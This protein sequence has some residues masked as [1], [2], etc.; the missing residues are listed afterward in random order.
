MTGKLK[1]LILMVLLIIFIVIQF[2][3]STVFGIG[4]TVLVQVQFD[5]GEDIQETESLPDEHISVTFHGTV[6]AELVAGKR[7]QKIVV[8]LYATSDQ[9]WSCV[10]N[11]S[12]M[13]L[14]SGD[15][16]PFTVVVTVPAG[17]KVNTVDTITVGGKGVAFPGIFQDII[18]PIQGTIVIVERY[19]RFALSTD[20]QFRDACTESNVNYNLTITNLGNCN[21]IFSLEVSN[22]NDLL[23]SQLSVSLSTFTI[24]VPEKSSNIV[25][26]T[27][28]V[29]NS[30]KCLGSHDI[31]IKV[32]CDM[33]TSGDTAPQN[34]VFSL[35][36]SD[37]I[38]SDDISNEDK[39]VLLNDLDN[40]D[41]TS[42]DNHISS[43][44]NKDTSDNFLPGFEG[45]I[46]L[47]GLFMVI[48][49]MSK[50]RN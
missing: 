3:P 19:H 5:E 27:V 28:S 25:V 7:V 37:P 6:S 14:N 24:D 10:I 17:T 36:I 2:V 49:I 8:S 11:P 42:K 9:G 47:I 35:S 50:K 41:E 38:I 4:P 46:F 16:E 39:T 21:D 12:Q 18:E 23:I 48:L 44:Q 22:F 29:P 15:T 31:V 32:K 33:D 34:F 20:I 1:H 13:T 30:D 43:N 26:V 40:Y 45:V